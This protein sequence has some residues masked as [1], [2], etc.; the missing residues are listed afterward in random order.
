MTLKCIKIHFILNNNRALNG[1]ASVGFTFTYGI[2]I[3]VYVSNLIRSGQY[4]SRIK[5]NNCNQYSNISG[6]TILYR[7]YYFFDLQ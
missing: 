4:Y 7:I 2:Y 5:F 3:N 1:T 6:Y